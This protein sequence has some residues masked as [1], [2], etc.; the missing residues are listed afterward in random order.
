MG[1][2]TAKLGSKSGSKEFRKSAP[3]PSAA[4]PSWIIICTRSYASTP[5]LQWVGSPLRARRRDEQVAKTRGHWP[6]RENN[7]SNS[8]KRV[9]AVSLG[10]I[11]VRARGAGVSK[12]RPQPPNHVIEGESDELFS[13]DPSA[14]TDEA[15]QVGRRA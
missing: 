2:V 9:A 10:E 11:P 12:T 6:P 4:S 7:L 14:S 13:R 5:M 3:Y 8:L 1:Q 15:A